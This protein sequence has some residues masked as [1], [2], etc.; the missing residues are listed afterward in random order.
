MFMKSAASVFMSSAL[1]LM[2]LSDIANGSA[3]RLGRSGGV[4]VAV[5][6][7][8]DEWRGTRA[9]DGFGARDGGGRRRRSDGARAVDATFGVR[10][11][12]YMSVTFGW[13]GQL[14]QK[15]TVSASPLIARCKSIPVGSARWSMS[16]TTAHSMVITGPDFAPT[17]IAPSPAA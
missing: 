7:R 11:R 1:G 4:V 3:R 2:D 15:S 5:S 10:E 14:P 17:A 12:W 13:C 6:E 8:V 9:G 16:F